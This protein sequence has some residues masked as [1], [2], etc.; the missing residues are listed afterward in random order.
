LFKSYVMCH[1][2]LSIV[3]HG[4]NVAQQG[5]MPSYIENNLCVCASSMC[6]RGPTFRFSHDLPSW[7]KRW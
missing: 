2:H 5:T 6:E 1:V 4:L 3:A 7:L